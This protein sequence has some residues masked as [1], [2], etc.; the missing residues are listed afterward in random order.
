MDEGPIERRNKLRSIVI[1]A[2]GLTMRLFKMRYFHLSVEEF[3]NS[4]NPRNCEMWVLDKI[5]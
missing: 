4:R 5:E 3:E 2:H 1:I